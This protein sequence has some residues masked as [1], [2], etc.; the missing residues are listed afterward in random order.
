MLKLICRNFIIAMLLSPFFSGVAFA[1][2]SESYTVPLQE[3]DDSKKD[4][5]PNRK[6][7]RIP[8]HRGVICII[9]PEGIQISID[10]ATIVAYELWD[11]SESCLIST[12]DEEELLQLLYSLEGDIVLR[13][14]TKDASYFGF[15]SL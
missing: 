8:A 12:P 1:A 11:D 9:T 14:L 15:L 6:G 7:N 3:E 13:I 5:D 2:G 10:P 4:N